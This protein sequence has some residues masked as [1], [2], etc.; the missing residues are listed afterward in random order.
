MKTLFLKRTYAFG[1][2]GVFSTRDSTLLAEHVT[3]IRTPSKL[4]EGF[5]RGLQVTINPPLH[6]SETNEADANQQYTVKLVMN[7]G[8]TEDIP[9]KL[10]TQLG[11]ELNRIRKLPYSNTKSLRSSH[12]KEPFQLTVHDHTQWEEKRE[13]LL[14][15]IKIKEHHTSPTYFV[16]PEA[17]IKKFPGKYTFRWDEGMDNPC[18]YFGYHLKNQDQFFAEEKLKNSEIA[19]LSQKYKDDVTFNPGSEAIR[20]PKLTHESLEKSL[21]SHGFKKL[22]DGR[23]S[24]SCTGLKKVFDEKDVTS[25][26]VIKISNVER[27]DIMLERDDYIQEEEETCFV[28]LVVSSE[29]TVLGINTLKEFAF[30]IDTSGGMKKYNFEPASLLYSNLEFSSKKVAR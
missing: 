3:L 8:S 15:W 26:F 23:L 10:I 21:T 19:F 28:D 24:G 27:Q 30:C 22:V 11:G 7:G 5:Q 16:D 29:G 9:S 25:N 1:A 4:H 14:Q 17:Y 13:S 12:L 20:I 18:L 6:L 2:I